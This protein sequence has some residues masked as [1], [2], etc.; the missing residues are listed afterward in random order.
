MAY[1]VLKLKKM[2]NMSTSGL[3]VP[4]FLHPPSPTLYLSYRS[5]H[6]ISKYSRQLSES[7]YDFDF[8]CGKGVSGLY[9]LKNWLFG[10]AATAVLTHHLV[11]LDG[12]YGR[13][14]K[15]TRKILGC[16]GRM[17]ALALA[18]GFFLFQSSSRRTSYGPR[19]SSLPA[20]V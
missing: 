13:F 18:C 15:K 12:Y 9:S 1:M 7:K 3:I 20:L 14:S 4:S 16:V 2:A 17:A 5:C 11:L 8:E 6:S 10:K 19:F